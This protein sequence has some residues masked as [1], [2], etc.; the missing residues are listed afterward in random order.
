LSGGEIA[1]M[2]LMDAIIRL[3][4][5]ALGDAQ[6]AL[7]DSFGDGLLDCPHYTRPL[8][9]HGLEV[10]PVLMSGHH[11]Q[12]AKWRRA[13]SLE[14]TLKKRPDLI[15]AARKAGR[16]SKED[17]AVLVQLQD[18]KMQLESASPPFV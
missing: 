18:K 1:A 12:I 11:A 9:Y 15:V 3:L 6:S 14:A 17:E 5:G 8:Q 7:Q 4:P 16:L 13:K 2:A 10:P